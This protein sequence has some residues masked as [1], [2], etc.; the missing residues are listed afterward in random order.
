M[1][2]ITVYDKDYCEKIIYLNKSYVA[3][4]VEIPTNEES[5]CYSDYEVR[6]LIKGQTAV[7]KYENVIKIEIL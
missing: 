3:S 1:I 2:K 7:E 4:M 5:E 6:L